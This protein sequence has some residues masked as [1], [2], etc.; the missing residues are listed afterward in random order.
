MIRVEPEIIDHIEFHSSQEE[1]DVLRAILA[2]ALVNFDHVDF[3]LD[4]VCEDDL[5]FL[6]SVFD[7]AEQPPF[8]M[9][10]EHYL[11]LS[12]IVSRTETM[13]IPNIEFES[14]RDVAAQI[15]DIDVLNPSSNKRIRQ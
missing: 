3:Y 14:H 2:Q 15:F 4:R 11:Q 8:I 13:I 5:T 6:L 1:F 12:A 7:T 10:L 9:R